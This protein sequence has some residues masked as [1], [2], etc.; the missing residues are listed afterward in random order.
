VTRPF[1]DNLPEDIYRLIVI[2]MGIFLILL[3]LRVAFLRWK[4][5]VG[6]R[7]RDSSPWALASYALFA[8]IPTIDGLQRFGEPLRWERS[9]LY[10]SA[11]ATGVIAAFGQV[12][13]T[14]WRNRGGRQPDPRPG[15][16]RVEG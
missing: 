8:A 2:G 7:L 5:P 14:M 11:L 9:I 4:S 10:A 1:Q 13:F 16:H 6:D 12:T 15:G 3:S